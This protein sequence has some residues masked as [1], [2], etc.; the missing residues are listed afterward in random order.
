MI[1]EIT[2]LLDC[3][4]E[5]GY[6][7]DGF[8]N[9]GLA[10]SIAAESMTSTSDFKLAGFLNSVDFPPISLVR[11]GIP[12]YPVNIFVNEKLKVAVFLSHLSLPESFSR[13]IAKVMLEYAKKH[14]C[15]KI[16]STVGMVMNPKLTKDIAAIGSTE[17]ARNEIKSL[18]IEMS[19]DL[20]IPGIPGMLLNQGRFSNQGVIVLLFFPKTKNSPDFESGAKLCL[21][22]GM[23]IPK[24]P[25]NLKI[26]KNES[27][28]AEKRIKKTQKETE[29]IR[30]TI[31]G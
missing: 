10:G 12:Y 23:F 14:H 18:G 17:N 11:G 20:T 31:Y 1:I 30:D 7:I 19:L 29:Q 22:M 15:K 28:K 3:D 4:L 13:A 6:V 24:L 26:I 21:T 2:E 9:V 27:A 5:G 16:I 25:C 8:P